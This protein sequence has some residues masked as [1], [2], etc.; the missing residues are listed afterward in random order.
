M[1]EVGVVAHDMPE[2]WRLPM[3]IIGLGSDWLSARIRMPSPR[4]IG[5]PSS[6]FLE[7]MVSE[8]F[9]FWETSDRAL[10]LPVA[11]YRVGRQS[12]CAEIPA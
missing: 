1:A 10:P 5:L 11:T 6:Q 7:E 12:S 9:E 3:G 4:R 2:N 8:H